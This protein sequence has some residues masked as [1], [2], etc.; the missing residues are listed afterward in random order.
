M[1]NAVIVVGVVAV[2]QLN[3]TQVY[4]LLVRLVCTTAN[5]LR[6]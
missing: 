3:S 6:L 4:D 1:E 5:L 2:V